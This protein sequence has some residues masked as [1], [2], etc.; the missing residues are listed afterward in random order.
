MHTPQ[1]ITNSNQLSNLRY[2]TLHAIDQVD[3]AMKEQR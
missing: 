1:L 3:C 2:N